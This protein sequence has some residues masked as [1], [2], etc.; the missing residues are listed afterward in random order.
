MYCR[1]YS[2]P[3]A[4]TTHE[5]AL[6]WS[7]ALKVVLQR[8]WTL[9]LRDKALVIARLVQVV[10]MSLIIGSLFANIAKTATGARSF[11]GVS[12]LSIMFLAMGAMPQLAT[13]FANKG[14]GVLLVAAIGVHASALGQSALRCSGCMCQIAYAL[15]VHVN[16]TYDV[17]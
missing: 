10:I 4:L 11:F 17:L 16:H 3:D 14:Y 9:A 6:T 12:F 8:Q 13:T 2:N 1:E 15:V 7:K 5:Y